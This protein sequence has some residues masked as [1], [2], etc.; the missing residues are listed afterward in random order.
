MNKPTESMPSSRSMRQARISAG[1]GGERLV[2]VSSSRST[3]D[4]I[5]KYTTATAGPHDPK[6]LMIDSVDTSLAEPAKL[7][8]PSA[9]QLSQT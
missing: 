8:E 3:P 4:S 9:H 1:L 6:T 5:P 2:D 7:L